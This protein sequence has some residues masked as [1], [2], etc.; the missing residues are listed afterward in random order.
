MRRRSAPTADQWNART[1][2]GQKRPAGWRGPQ[3]LPKKASEGE[4]AKNWRRVIDTRFPQLALRVVEKWR[5]IGVQFFA[6]EL[7]SELLNIEWHFSPTTRPGELW[8]GELLNV[9]FSLIARVHGADGAA[10][11]R[12]AKH[13]QSTS[14]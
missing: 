2:P 11:R 1:A 12:V 14:A 10:R 13:V 7:L 5:V 9:E 4:L 6:S 3:D 8:E